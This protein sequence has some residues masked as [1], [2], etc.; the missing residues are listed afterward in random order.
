MEQHHD[1]HDE[2]HMPATSIAPL[3][4]AAGMT[5]TLVGILSTPLLVLGVILLL[6]GIAMWVL[7]P[8]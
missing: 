5:F 3:L 6:G 8:S 2:I 4:V 7:A 1:T